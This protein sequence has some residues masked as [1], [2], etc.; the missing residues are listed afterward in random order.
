[1][2][3]KEALAR[4][5]KICSMQ[6][7]CVADIK[8][9]LKSW[10]IDARQTDEIVKYLVANRFVDEQRYSG[11]Y[12]NDKFRLNG[13]GK[14]KIAYALKMKGIEEEIIRSALQK[15]DDDNYEQ[16]LRGLLQKK[17]KTIKTG[18]ILLLKQKLFRFAATKGYETE[19]INHAIRLLGLKG[20]KDGY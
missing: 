2:T 3:N 20:N 8:L 14:T 15:I 9:K 10:K 7:K 1:M 16:T 17:M 19:T 18:N 12:A 5:M 6:E 11:S 13:W 4:L